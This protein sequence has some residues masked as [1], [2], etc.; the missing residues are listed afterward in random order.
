MK[1]QHFIFGLLF[2]WVVVTVSCSSDGVEQTATPAPLIAIERQ[3]PTVTSTLLPT[4]TPAATETPLA[5]ATMEATE[6]TN[7]YRNSYSGSEH[8]QSYNGR[9]SDNTSY[10]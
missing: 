4:G 3:L 6:T 8:W 2:G 10:D 1:I 9:L 7:H 5:T